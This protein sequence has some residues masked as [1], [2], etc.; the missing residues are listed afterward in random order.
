MVADLAAE[1]AAAVAAELPAGDAF[2]LDVRDAE[3]IDALVARTLERFGR[4]DVRSTARATARCGRC[5]S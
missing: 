4:V 5:S 3:R 1:G 2:T